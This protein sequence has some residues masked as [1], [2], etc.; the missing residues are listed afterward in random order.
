MLNFDI[1]LVVAERLETSFE[2]GFEG[3]SN[4]YSNF[5]VF[6]NESR[7]LFA[8]YIE[9]SS[10]VKDCILSA[11]STSSFLPSCVEAVNFESLEEGLGL[12]E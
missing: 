3:F 10:E 6:P 11:L 4:F 8:F 2:P 7:V 5:L 9:W 12:Y 1:E